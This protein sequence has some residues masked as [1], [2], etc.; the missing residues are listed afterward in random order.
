M[1]EKKHF[2]DVDISMSLIINLSRLAQ[3]DI[4]TGVLDPQLIRG[5]PEKSI[6]AIEFFLPMSIAKTAVKG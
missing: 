3:K 2:E 4:C 1:I 5:N 6:S